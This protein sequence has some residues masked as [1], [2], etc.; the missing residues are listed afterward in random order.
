VALSRSRTAG[1][2]VLI[3]ALAFGFGSSVVLAPEAIAHV[4]V[5][6]ITVV[7]G[8]VLTRH[9]GAEFTAA[10]E[11]DVL[12]AGD[13]IRTGPGGAAEITYFE[14]SSVRLEAETEIVI[15]TLRTEA[16]GGTAIGMMQ[17][18]GRTWHV[19]TKLITGSSRYEVRTPSSTA[20]VRGT[21]F[22]VDVHVDADGPTATVTTSEGVVVH[23]A[24]DPKAAG[25]TQVRVTAGQESTKSASRPAEPVHAAPPATLREAPARPAS[26]PRPTKSSPSS[27]DRANPRSRARAADPVLVAAPSERDRAKTSRI[28]QRQRV[29]AV[30]R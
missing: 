17:M 24:A 30:E 1:T 3:V 10:R 21:I 26:T 8:Q 16:D 29:K 25:V 22:A 20:S 13:T 12:V 28:P 6:A 19:V 15:E 5:S 4:A 18:L 23:T 9:G 14:G 2:L 7:N 11:G 27:A